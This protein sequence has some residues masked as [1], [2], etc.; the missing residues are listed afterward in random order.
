VIK[1]LGQVFYRTVFIVAN[2]LKLG[3]FRQTSDA[4]LASSR[5]AV[6]RE[7]AIH[8]YTLLSVASPRHRLL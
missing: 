1:E 5:A 2:L 6:D 3:Y 4:T 7:A 8:V